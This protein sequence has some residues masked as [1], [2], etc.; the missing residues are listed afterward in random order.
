MAVSITS[1]FEILYDGDSAIGGADTY[2]GFQRYGSACNGG[3]VSRGTDHFTTTVPSF[4]LVGRRISTWMTA[5]ASA[6]AIADGGYRIVIGDGTNSRAYY[7][8][9]GDVAAFGQVGWNCF[10]LDGDVLP[11]IFEQ[12]SGSAEPNVAAI[13]EVGIGFNITTKAV[14]NSPNV[15]W[16]IMQVG[17][18]LIIE[19]GSPAD[20]GTFGDIV[21]WDEGMDAATGT[22]RRVGEGVYSTNYGLV[23]GSTTGDSYFSDTNSLLFFEG[24]PTG[25]MY[26]I[27]T[28]GGTGTNVFRLGERLGSGDSSIGVSGVTIQSSEPWTL[29]TSDPNCTSEL[30]GSTF[31]GASNGVNLSG[32]FRSCIL[33][34]SSKAIVGDT[35][36]KFST[37][38]G[39]ASNDGALL[40]NENA[41]IT[42][43]NF[44]GNFAAIEY[45]DAGTYTHNNLVFS[46]NTYDVNFSGSGDLVINA[47]GTSN[48]ST[49]TITGTGTVTIDNPVSLTFSGLEPDTEVRIYDQDRNELAGV[50]NIM[51]TFTYAYNYTPDT[52]ITYVIFNI[53]FEAIKERLTLPANDTTLPIRQVFDR[54]YSNP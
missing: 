16:D 48:T 40:W 51:D 47:S 15:F 54:V 44:N 14:G 11:P 24:V 9:G 1:T 53:Q 3:Q 6:A 12:L 18:G 36:I 45:P 39:T 49:F 4:S 29:D 37:F 22:I 41:D 28:Q 2:S 21:A 43:S 27:Q 46:G 52:E 34:N 25:D 31:R 26:K 13:T 20:P 30:L 42:D 35:N 50:E 10:V 33:N 5:P 8:G 23:F 7:V 38:S 19:G 17:E 32:E